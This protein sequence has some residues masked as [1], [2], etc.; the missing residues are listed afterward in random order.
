MAKAIK[1]KVKME[2]TAGTGTFFVAEKN[3]IACK[4]VEKSTSQKTAFN[5]LFLHFN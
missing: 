5:S 4:L 1:V 2:S 3:F